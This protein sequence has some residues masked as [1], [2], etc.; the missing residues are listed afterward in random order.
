MD[1]PEKLGETA[2]R[3]F[4][5]MQHITEGSP[6]HKRFLDWVSTSPAHQAEYA[7][8]AELWQQLDSTKDLDNI[9]SAMQQKT[10]LDKVARKK[11]IKNT[12]ASIGVFISCGLLAAISLQ[13]YQTWQA[14]PVMQLARTNPIGSISSQVLEDGTNVTLNAN[15]Q[16]QV[17]FYRHQRRVL[18]KQGEAV[19]EVAKDKQRPFVV[20]TGT[21]KI[22]VLGTRFAINKLSRLV[23][24]SVDHGSVE[25]ESDTGASMILHD[26]QVAEIQP[27][28]APQTIQRNAADA[29]GF[30][31]GQLVFDKADIYEI[32]ETLS[33]YRQQPL[34]A[35]GNNKA[36]ITAV[37]NIN[38]SEQFLQSLPSI[39]QV[40]V[41]HQ[42]RQTVIQSKD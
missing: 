13:Q 12:L 16:M 41:T 34:I 2:A 38:N 17:T 24:V 14:Q 11:T 22:T 40:K 26:G 32:A 19:F 36:R 28:E 18:L 39:A 10:F 6:E 5:R 27:R 29:F 25:V 31:Q 21:A 4:I 30:T 15:S 23:R 35:Q 1:N 9:I 20:E 37:I 3:W 33:R 8:I 42:A 7:S